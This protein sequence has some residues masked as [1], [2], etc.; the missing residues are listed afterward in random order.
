MTETKMGP[1]WGHIWAYIGSEQGGWKKTWMWSGEMEYTPSID[2]YIRF[3]QNGDTHTIQSVTF[4][5]YDGSLD[6]L[7]QGLYSSVDDLQESDT[8]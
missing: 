2:T 6:I 4:N 1:R 7:I 5:C 8:K 3:N